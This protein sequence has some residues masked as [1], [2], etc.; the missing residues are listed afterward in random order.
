MVDC[1]TNVKVQVDIAAWARN[2]ITEDPVAGG[3]REGVSDFNTLVVIFVTLE[4]NEPCDNLTLLCLFIFSPVQRSVR[5]GQQ[6]SV[7][8]AICSVGLSW[9]GRSASGE[10]CSPPGPCPGHPISAA[11]ADLR[12]V[13]WSCSLEDTHPRDCSIWHYLCMLLTWEHAR[14]VC[15]ILV[16]RLTVNYC[17]LNEPVPVT[18]LCLGSW[19][20]QR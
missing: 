3:G 9:W 12:W 13:G 1:A 17:L 16:Q 18:P 14:W 6:V 2:V 5:A 15:N 4:E 7:Y 19:T 11:L 10:S 20:F 8:F